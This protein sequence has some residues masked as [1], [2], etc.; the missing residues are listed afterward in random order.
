M[1]SDRKG[2]AAAPQIVD[3]PYT[4]RPKPAKRWST[5]LKNRALHPRN[6][7]VITPVGVFASASQAAEAH[8]YTAGYGAHLAR[9]G[10]HGWRWFQHGVDKGQ[11][12]PIRG[13]SRRPIPTNAKRVITPDGAYDSATLAGLAHGITPQA[14]CQ[15]ASKGIKGWRY[16]AARSLADK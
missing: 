9:E 3:E 4:E 5:H 12:Q 13:R 8:G 11:V 16:A 7:Q 2:P 10:L 15:R 1:E 14:A 6:R